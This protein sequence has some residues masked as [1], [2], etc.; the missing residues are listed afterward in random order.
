[1]A[2]DEWCGRLA[3][4]CQSDVGSLRS[5]PP[6]DG[7]VAMAGVTCVG[8]QLKREQAKGM[9]TMAEMAEMAGVIPRWN[10]GRGRGIGRTWYPRFG[11]LH[12]TWRP[13]S[14]AHWSTE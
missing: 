14:T 2:S 10:L 11:W 1:M 4:Q 8:E 9:M 12:R 7:K 6:V 13:S 5:L 3:V